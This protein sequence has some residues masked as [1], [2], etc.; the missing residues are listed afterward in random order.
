MGNILVAYFSATDVTKKVATSLAEGV[1]ADLFE[2]EPL[3]PY[4]REDLKWMNKKSRSSIEMKDRSSR[5]AIKNKVD[6]SK[7]DFIFLGFPVWWYREPSIID[8]F[9]EQYDFTGKTI[10]PFATSAGS[11]I[12]EAPDNIR[13][14]AKNARVL[15]GERLLATC[16]EEVLLNWVKSLNLF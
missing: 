7:Y 12:G 10:I 1:K 6:M 5:P 13:G 14:L 11:Q 16:S 2:I 9:A 3:V 8:T 15:D 4:T